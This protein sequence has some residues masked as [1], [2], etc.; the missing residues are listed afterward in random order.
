[1]FLLVLITGS[2]CF[3]EDET[4]AYNSAPGKNLLNNKLTAMNSYSHDPTVLHDVKLHL[5]L[6]FLYERRSAATMTLHLRFIILVISILKVPK[7][8]VL[9]MQNGPFQNNIYYWI[10]IIDQSP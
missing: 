10:I 3:R 4:S 8:K 5:L 2:V 6:L 1:M 9:I 7:V